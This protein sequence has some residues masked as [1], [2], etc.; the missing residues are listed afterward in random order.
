MF[1]DI[2]PEEMTKSWLIQIC[3]DSGEVIHTFISAEKIRYTT[4]KFA[5]LR[6]RREDEA[7]RAI[8]ELNGANIRGSIF[9]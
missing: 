1:I 3:R 4:S 7:E 8:K 9:Q 2:L 6:Y 5:F